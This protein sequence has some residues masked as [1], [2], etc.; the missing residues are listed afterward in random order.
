[1]DETRRGDLGVETAVPAHEGKP[2]I[3]IR[4]TCGAVRGHEH[5]TE[6]EARLCGCYHHSLEEAMLLRARLVR[7]QARAD[8]AEALFA[9]VKCQDMQV[10]YKGKAYVGQRQL[11]DLTD[12]LKAN[13]KKAEMCAEHWRR[14]AL[15][16]TQEPETPQ[17][18][19]SD[20]QCR[21]APTRESQWGL[22]IS[23]TRD[24]FG[25][26][27]LVS[28]DPHGAGYHSHSLIVSHCPWCGEP[29]R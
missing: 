26:W 28:C 8:W 12:I 10:T 2:A 15:A 7:E 29:L 23:L 14:E 27:M 25:T 20:H 1:M 5:A 11:F 18:K 19:P 21:R 16:E 17:R 6:E 13:L 4:W 3:P 22:E 24:C 9:E